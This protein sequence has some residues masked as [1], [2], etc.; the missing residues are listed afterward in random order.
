MPS[1]TLDDLE[2]GRLADSLK[3]A[4][5]EIQAVKK[6]MTESN[7]RVSQLVP[8]LKELD[9]LA[10]Q[11]AEVDRQVKDVKVNLEKLATV[12]ETLAEKHT[13]LVEVTRKQMLTIGHA[14]DTR[15]DGYVYKGQGSHGSLFKSRRQAQE[16]GM[17]FMATM[18]ESVNPN[19]RRQARNWLRDQGQS[20]RFIPRMTEGLIQELGNAWEKTVREAIRKNDPDYISEEF[21]GTSPPGAVLVFPEFIKTLIRNVELH[22]K[23]RQNATIWPMS[24]NLTHIPRRKTGFTYPEW[25]GEGETI[26]DN[27]PDVDVLSLTAKKMCNMFYYSN[28]LSADSAIS[29]ADHVMFEMALMFASEE[30]RVGF[31]GTGTGGMGPTGYAGFIG[32]LGSV[33]NGDTDMTPFAVTGAATQDLTT[34]IVESKLREMTGKLHT[35]ALANAKW[36]M[37][38]SVHADLDGIQMGTSGGS[39]VK[40]QDPKSPTIMGHPVIDV[41]WMPVSP[42]AAS[43]PMLFLGDLR[44]AMYLGDRMSP[45]VM[46]SEHFRFDK[47][48]LAVRGTARVGFRLVQGNGLVVY[49]TGTA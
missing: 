25:E 28:E 47:D 4:T 38:R 39:V 20:L 9:D 35:W 45:E 10:K 18:K 32:V 23:L 22:G 48:Q 31:N 40:Y 6:E 2:L 33:R 26:G 7:N 43:T 37:H 46:T 42:G 14:A 30:D 5:S 11:G 16:I 15:E 49:V 44:K 8:K 21:T 24:S 19:A 41:D 36:Y 3:S 27:D 17:F 29:M 13:N 12:M 34:E 1:A